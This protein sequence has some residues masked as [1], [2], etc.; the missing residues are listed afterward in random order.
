MFYQNLNRTPRRFPVPNKLT[1]D[2]VSVSPDLKHKIATATNTL[3]AGH[4]GAEVPEEDILNF[5]LN[6]E[7]LEAEFYTYASTGKS[8]ASFGV[9]IDGVATGENPQAGGSTVGGSEIDFNRNE[10]FSKETA[11]EI[12]AEERAH[13]NLLRS[14]LGSSAVAKPN[15]DL[16]ALGIGFGSETEFLTVARLL[17][18]IGVS[19]YS[20]AVSLFRTPELVKTAARLLAAESQH[21]GGIRL[22]VAVLDIV[23]TPLDLADLV[24]PPS[25]KRSQLFSI[26]PANGLTAIRTAGE[27]LYLAYGMKV[28]A[29]EGGF[30]PDGLN[31]NI[32]TSS[33]PATASNL[34]DR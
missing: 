28:G 32:R 26:N 16:N 8:I 6:L 11:L 13:V 4:P 12:G 21:A 1:D 14:A 17:E 34:Y 20:G 25:G 30:F 10:V 22:Q 3:Q 18:D 27:V 23:T 33:A 7:Y 9:G 29:T 5:A 24:P 19:G 15:I 2:V 31:G